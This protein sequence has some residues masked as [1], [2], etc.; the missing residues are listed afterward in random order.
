[1]KQD[2]VAKKKKRYED[3]LHRF[4]SWTKERKSNK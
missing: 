2:K 1:M 4:V 3:N